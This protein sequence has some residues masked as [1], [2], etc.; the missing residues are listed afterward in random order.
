MLVTQTTQGLEADHLPFLFD[1]SAGEAGR[2]IAH[3]ARANPVWHTVRDGCL[4]YTS[5]CV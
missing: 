5:R 4:L 1:E 3:V 2:L